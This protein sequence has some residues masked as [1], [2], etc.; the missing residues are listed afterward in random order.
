MRRR[1]R[2]STKKKRAKNEELVKAYAK[3]LFDESRALSIVFEALSRN[4][5]SGS[6]PYI[7]M[8][9]ICTAVPILI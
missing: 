6:I 8:D 7:V 1:S 5:D 3:N 2:T 9:P 4:M